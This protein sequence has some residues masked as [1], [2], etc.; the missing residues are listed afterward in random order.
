VRLRPP[1]G[2]KARTRHGEI[3]LTAVARVL[4][5]ITI[6]EL[7][8]MDGLR[9]KEERFALVHCRVLGGLRR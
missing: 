3:Y 7:A 2:L 6:P 4:G 5:E 9:L 8:F 1:A